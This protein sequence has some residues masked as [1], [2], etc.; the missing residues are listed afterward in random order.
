[1]SADGLASSFA[2]LLKPPKKHARRC[3][4]HYALLARRARQRRIEPKVSGG[5]NRQTRYLRAEGIAVVRD[6]K[7]PVIKEFEER[8]F[9][10]LVS[11]IAYD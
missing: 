7:K 3:E 6:S 10:V 2:L 1:L 5:V 8:Q 9:F 4:T 11:R